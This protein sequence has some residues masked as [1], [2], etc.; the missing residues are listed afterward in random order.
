MRVGVSGKAFL[1][2]AVLLLAF[3]T[4]AVFLAAYL[5]GA[6]QQVTGHNLLLDLT[7]KV[8]TAHGRVLEFDRD[9][10]TKPTLAATYFEYAAAD[11]EGA[12]HAVDRFLTDEPGHPRR[13]EFEG[14]ARRLAELEL[15]TRQTQQALI[16]YFEERPQELNDR[17]PQLRNDLDILKAELQ[18]E[19]RGVASQMREQWKDAVQMGIILGGAGLLAAIG[20]ALWLWR[21]LR[22]LQELRL[23]ARRIASGDY[24]KRIGIYSRD[25]IGDLAREFDGMA[26]ALQEREQR[27]I[28]SERLATVGK[29]AAQ[30]THEIRNPLSSIGL[31]AELLVDELGPAQAEGRRLLEVISGEIDRLSEIT[32]SYLRYVRLPRPKLLPEDPAALVSAVME[33]ARAELALAKITLELEAPAGLPEIAADENQLRQALLNLVRNAREAMPDGGRLQVAVAAA[34]AGDRVTLRVADTGAGIAPQHIGRIFEP[35]FSTK[36]KGTGLGLALVQHIV[37][38]HGGKIE[39]HSAGQ[40]GTVFELSFPVLR[41]PAAAMPTPATESEEE[42]AAVPRPARALAVPN[43]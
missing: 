9:G 29:V 31:N 4:N 27:L 35:F 30:I 33:F 24:G 14:H 41:R 1:G 39:V 3:G 21:T 23:K 26:W 11:L 37:T 34:A 12:R 10:R 20:A 40:K 13:Q 19:L 32:E 5:H 43:R 16:P 25:E 38:E 28:R 15:N 22:P 7:A 18:R 8:E 42:A 36:E 17:F 2:Y 6:R